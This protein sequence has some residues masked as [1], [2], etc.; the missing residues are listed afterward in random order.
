MISEINQ[1]LFLY[2]KTLQ[3]KVHGLKRT[4]PKW[5]GKQKKKPVEFYR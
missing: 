3:I 2:L 1:G 4:K 5:Q